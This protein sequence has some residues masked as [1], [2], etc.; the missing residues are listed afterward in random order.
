M[1]VEPLELRR[2]LAGDAVI[3]EFLASNSRGLRDEDGDT[4]DWVELFNPRDTSVS[5]AGWHLTDSQDNLAKWE[6]PAINLDA[7]QYLVVFASG[8][9]RRLPA[10]SLHTSFQLSAGGEYLALVR[11][12]GSVAHAYDPQFPAQTTDVSY[13]L[14]D[15]SDLSTV[16]LFSTP[17]PGASNGS[18]VGNQGPAITDVQHAPAVARDNDPIVVTARV[19]SRPSPVAS[20]TLTYRVMYGEELPLSMVD[21][22][23]GS[24]QTA[25][26]GI[27]TA[28]IPASASEPGQMVRGMSAPRTPVRSLV[29]PVFQN[30][31]GS[32]EYLGTVV[33]EQ[34]PDD[35][36]P[37]FEWFIRPG[38]ESRAKTLTGTRASLFYDGE[39]YDNILVR[40]RGVS[41][42]DIAKNPFKF[43]FNP[44]YEF[45]YADDKPR[46]DEFDLSTTFRDKAYIRQ[47]LS[48]ELYRDAGVV[49]SETF[50]VHVRRNDAFFSVAI[51]VEHP[52]GD[53]LDRNGLDR[54]GALYKPIVDA[55][56]NPA[57]F[58]KL[59]PDDED[60]SDLAAL[61]AGL[62]SPAD[63]RRL[64]LYDNVDIP[65]V[66]NYLTAS[67]IIQH[68]DRV[69]TNFY[70]YRDT[71]GTRE[72]TMLPWD[73]DLTFGYIFP[74]DDR[75]D[76]DNDTPGDWPP[77]PGMSHP[78]W[79]AKGYPYLSLSNRMIEAI[80][81][82]PETREMYNRRLR[83]LMDEFLQPPGTPVEDRY[84]ES[85]I[86]ELQP[87]MT[88]LAAQDLAKWGT[89]GTRQS[90]AQALDILRND[91]LAV[92]RQHLF[93]THTSLNSVDPRV[94]IPEYA[95]GRY[96]VPSDN[97]LGVTWTR[98]TFDDNSWASGM[99]GLG[100]E[101]RT[102][103]FVDVLKTQ[104]KP[105]DTAADGT[106]I[107]LRIPFTVTDPT[108]IKDLTLQMKYDDGF[109]AYLN[110][111]EVARSNIRIAGTPG[112]NERAITQTNISTPRFENFVISS[113]ANR[114]RAGENILAI[115]A[116]N[117]T[118]TNTDM[119]ILPQLVEGVITDADVA[120]IP[121][122]QIGNPAIR[123]DPLD[124]DVSPTSGNQDQEYVKLHNPLDVAVD[125][126][127]WRLTGGIEH[128]IHPGT[129]IPARTSLYLTPDAYA[130]R[131]RATG[132]SGGQGLFVQGNYDGHLSNLGETMTLLA[133]DGSLID[134]LVTPFQPTDLQ[135]YLRVTELHYNPSGSD[136]S[137]E[138]IELG[139]ISQGVNALTLDVSGVTL[140]QGPRVPYTIPQDTLLAAGQSVV[141]VNNVAAFRAAYP[142]VEPSRILGPFDGNFSN[143]GERIKL[144]DARGNTIVDFV[145]D[146][147]APWPVAANG[148]GS[149][150][151][152]Q[153]SDPFSSDAASWLAAAP[154]P[155]RFALSAIRGDF[156]GD[157]R[158]DAIDIDL[159][160]AQLRL[161]QPNTAFDL[162][163][164]GTV[165]QADRDELIERILGTTYGDANL[166]GIFDSADFVR[167]FQFGRYEDDVPLNAGWEQGD[168]DGDGE[169]G[170]SDFIL[171]FQAGG[172]EVNSLR[173]KSLIPR[174]F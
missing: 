151:H 70:L 128:T 127:G 44:G 72:W 31:L 140:S 122:A 133:T 30:P 35:R 49:Y 36:L 125:V 139:N 147:R 118:P 169:F 61:I 129:I 126:S 6:F 107:F 113:Y 146:D 172:Y 144:D 173:R 115:H 87:L 136:E 94:L 2:L 64:F 137:T 9:D 82:T 92:R 90:F 91:Y 29:R 18:V 75:I 161:P 33:Q 56:T 106:S 109:V 98:T 156:N 77:I 166:D 145:Y 20:V 45:R 76:A 154:T 32:P 101:N 132:P 123:F 93:V 119:L 104:V 22:G 37:V 23:T 164:D 121:A 69:L 28:A 59:R 68:S 8:K 67:V 62:N 130:F 97:S 162:T 95:T 3:N 25:G 131:T 15:S 83:T 52:D 81:R 134:T 103:N 168:W 100:Y 12:D 159:L 13:G 16:R 73:T 135:R 1:V 39:F 117:A 17:T 157:G 158:V 63:D 160:S 24:D 34:T 149:S 19:D 55:L 96:F 5:L 84:F 57:N 110:G 120:G 21:N 111:V 167:I 46:V 7:G 47:L 27:F 79:G 65:S 165:N 10:A 153:D 105:S 143:Q 42:A 41:S 102:T 163:G 50:P 155:G 114:L 26:D 171:A 43:E 88:E 48:F 174:L 60:F 4:S 142:L 54:D 148:T 78:W 53:Y 138:F 14:S 170:T 152:W 124:F 74:S 66:I 150:L 51:F 99:T 86:N 116:V 108:Q 11:P 112:F 141:L 89:W 40:M 71:Q 85:R 38:T 80:I 58:E